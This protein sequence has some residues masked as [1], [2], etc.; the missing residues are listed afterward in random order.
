LNPRIVARTQRTVWLK[1]DALQP[2]GSFKI[3][4]I[5]Y[6]CEEYARR[7]ARRFI[8]SSGVTQACGGL[9]RTPSGHRGHGR[10]A[11]ERQRTREG[12]DSQENAK[13]SFMVRLE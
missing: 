7:G 13:S 8:S 10:G 9:R 6:A 2:P 11:T 3:R 1:M 4:G 5:G 12:A